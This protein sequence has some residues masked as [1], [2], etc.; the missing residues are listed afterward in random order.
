MTETERNDLVVQHLS[1]ARSEASRVYQIVH[2]RIEF[3]DL[4]AEAAYIMVRAAERYEEDRGVFQAFA[5]RAIAN[6]LVDYLRRWFRCSRN[7]W[8]QIQAGIKEPVSLTADM[9]ID[10]RVADPDQHL[11]S[12]EEIARLTNSL[13][14][15]SQT[16]LTLRY[17]N[18]L[19]Y[20][21]IAGLMGKSVSDCHQQHYSILQKLRQQLD[22]AL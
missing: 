14:W 1:L 5:R 4:Y 16:L 11:L 2:G 20:P 9:V 3:D 7:V 12:Q 8:K 22:F 15:E 6:G 17:Q 19:A 13:D 10:A 21:Q 18:G